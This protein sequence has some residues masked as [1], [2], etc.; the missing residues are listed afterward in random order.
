MVGFGAAPAVLQFG[1]LLFLPETPRWLFKN[2]HPGVART[3]LGKV[4]NGS[5][6]MVEEVIRAMEQEI[7]EEEAIQRPTCKSSPDDGPSSWVLPRLHTWTEL[8][9]HG[10][11]RRALTI[12]CLLQGLQQLCGFVRFLLQPIWEVM[13]WTNRPTELS[14]VFLGHHIF[15]HRILVSHTDIPLDRD[16]ELPLYPRCLDHHRPHWTS[17]DPLSH[18]PGHDQRPPALFG[19]IPIP[20]PAHQR[21]DH[22]H[23]SPSSPQHLRS[24]PSRH[25]HP[26]RSRHL[27][28][29]LCHRA[30]QHRMATR[31]TIPLFGPFS[32][33]RSRDGHQLG[34]QFRR[35][36]DIFTHDALLECHVDICHICRDMCPGLGRGVVDIPRN[37]RVGL[38]GRQGAFAGRMGRG[39][40]SAAGEKGPERGF[41]MRRL[42]FAPS[43]TSVTHRTRSFIKSVPTSNSLMHRTRPVQEV[44][45]PWHA[46]IEVRCL[47]ST[48]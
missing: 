48:S 11:N 27:R 23:S 10:G 13:M 22:H 5:E 41:N 29:R 9:G 45:P 17:P 44:V 32:R 25:S 28:V 2:G 40:E 6:S 4:Y 12:A 33:V 16:H 8:F 1:L 37:Q 19:V 24:S 38:R 18:P 15:L 47:C 30:R 46:G 26:D 39:R 34:Q 20:R 31:R 36:A 3:V 43:S 35:R 7:L 14:H 21:S 42:E